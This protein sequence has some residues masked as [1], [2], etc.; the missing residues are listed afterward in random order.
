MFSKLRQKL[1]W[2]IL[3]L[4]SWILYSYMGENSRASCCA[5][6]RCLE[7]K[8]KT[9]S[10]WLIHHI[11]LWMEGCVLCWRWF[12]N[13]RRLSLSLSH[14]DPIIIFLETFTNEK[15]FKHPR[16]FLFWWICWIMIIYSFWFD[17]LDHLLNI[18]NS[19]IFGGYELFI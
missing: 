5:F 6:S 10:C 14:R 19:K 4:S 1:L 8:G 2:N 18:I 9:F 17:L 13:C 7:R 12:S 3:V 15:Y 16:S 11:P